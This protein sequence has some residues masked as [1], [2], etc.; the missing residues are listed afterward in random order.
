MSARVASLSVPAMLSHGVRGVAPHRCGRGPWSLMALEVEG[1]RGHPVAITGGWRKWAP[2]A[3]ET[4]GPAGG[5]KSVMVMCPA[6][7]RL[8]ASLPQ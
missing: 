5:S 2:G 1:C 3:G 8:S 7:P 4:R 6:P